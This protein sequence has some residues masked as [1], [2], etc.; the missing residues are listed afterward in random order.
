MNNA[1]QA[2]RGYLENERQYSAYTVRN[3][4]KELERALPLLQ[5][6][7]LTDW[8]GLRTQHCQALL[9]KLHRQGLS[10]RSL[11]LTLSALRQLI[12]F[13]LREGT[14]THDPMVGVQAPKQG[15][16]L[17]KNLDVDQVNR[18]LELNDDDP[19]V[20]RDRAMMELFYS[21]GLRLAEL[22]AL[23][24]PQ[25]SLTDREVRVMGK[26]GKERILPVGNKA[27]EWLAKYLALRPALLK[28]KE[29]AAL[30]LSNRG[31]RISRRSV[32]A[33]LTEWGQSQALDSK[34]HPHKLRHSFATHLLESSK[35]LRAVQELLGHAN[36][37]TTQ[38]YTHL[39]FQHLASVYDTAHPRAKKK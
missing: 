16:P 18:L 26:G 30:F 32:Q 34:V 35:D 20:I 37:S 3:Y 5:A 28:G 19:L 8:Q 7:G 2:F 14:L 27:S 4:L 1:L 23:D 25:L 11:S 38:I 6:Q 29:C 15:R 12:K 39:D 10:P 24:C 33:R 36:L 22:V 21:S 31:S 17:P 13:L 9:A